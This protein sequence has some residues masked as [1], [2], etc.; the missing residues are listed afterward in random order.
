MNVA[1]L[2]VSAQ[3]V[4]VRYPCHPIPMVYHL[5][6][7]YFFAAAGPPSTKSPGTQFEAQHLSL[8]LGLVNINPTV[9]PGG[10]VARMGI[11]S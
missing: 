1:G 9:G 5:L 10:V 3:D 8:K 6:A 11:L 4:S 7:P 2:D